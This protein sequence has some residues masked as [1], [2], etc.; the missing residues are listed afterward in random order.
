MIESGIP[1][2]CFDCGNP[3]EW[4]GKPLALD[5]DHINGDQLDN[6]RENLRFACPNCHRQTSTWGRTID[7]FAA[8]LE[9]VDKH[10]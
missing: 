2:A 1:Y 4:R 7:P 3:G 6:R 5:I 9:L 8:V 10:A